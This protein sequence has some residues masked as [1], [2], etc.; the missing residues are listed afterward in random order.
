MLLLTWLCLRGTSI[1]DMTDMH[2]PTEITSSHIMFSLPGVSK[3]VYHA[4][5]F[6]IKCRASLVVR[7]PGIPEIIQNLPDAKLP[8]AVSAQAFRIFCQKSPAAASKMKMM[9]QNTPELV[10]GFSSSDL[11]VSSMSHVRLAAT[12]KHWEKQRHAA[13][14]LFVGRWLPAEQPE[15]L[16]QWFAFVSLLQWNLRWK[17]WNL[18]WFLLEQAKHHTPSCH[19]HGP[20]TQRFEHHVPCHNPLLRETAPCRSTSFSFCSL[21]ASCW[22]ARNSDVV[23]CLCQPSSVKLELNAVKLPWFYVEASTHHHRHL[24]TTLHV[25][26]Q[27]LG[28]QHTTMRTILVRKTVPQRLAVCEKPYNKG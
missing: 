3:C 11:H 18:L 6:L 21:L 4:P 25:R 17:P 14:S 8:E 16:M 20:C 10:S 7:P 28:R 26:T 27:H 23:V 19:T 15:T 9:S 12:T 2:V 5:G 13:T 24:S 22:T 1:P